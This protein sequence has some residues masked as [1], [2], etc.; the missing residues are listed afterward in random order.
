M[1]KLIL[2][3]MLHELISYIEGPYFLGDGGLLG[4]IREKDLLD[5]D[6]DLDLYLLPGTVIN[7]P[8]NSN[9]DIAKYYMDSK[10][11]RK[12]THPPKFNK[13]IEY[14]SF[15]K[16]KNMNLNLNR[17]QVCSLASKTYKVEAI[18]AKWPKPYIDIFYLKLEFNRYIYNYWPQYFKIEEIE[19]L[20]INNDLGFDVSIPNLPEDILERQYGDWE[21]VNKEFK[22]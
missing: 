3:E 9:L 13:W 21:V 12:Q 22:Y 18:D 16:T 4:L 10:V 15:I 5:H 14:C 11:Y 6:D 19:P 8:T 20:Q 2:K 7:I 1:V 17:A